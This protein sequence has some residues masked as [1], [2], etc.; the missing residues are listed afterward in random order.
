M[1]KVQTIILGW[2]KFYFSTEKISRVLRQ[3][4]EVSVW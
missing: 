1:T 3:G 4:Y 2:T